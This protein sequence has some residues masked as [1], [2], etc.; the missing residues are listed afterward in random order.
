L[1]LLFVLLLLDAPLPPLNLFIM[2]MTLSP[3]SFFKSNTLV[4]ASNRWS[5]G[6]PP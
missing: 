6:E 3:S 1:L 2:L 5:T 4:A